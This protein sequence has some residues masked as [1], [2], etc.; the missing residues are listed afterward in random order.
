MIVLAKQSRQTLNDARLGL[1]SVPAPTEITNE[2]LI[3]QLEAILAGGTY[4]G[5]NNITT[6]ISAGNAQGS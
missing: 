2:A 5:T 1:Q 4:A 3:A 6:V